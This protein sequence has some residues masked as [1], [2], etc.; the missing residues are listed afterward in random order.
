MTK[1]TDDFS[2]HYSVTP[3]AAPRQI[4]VLETGKAYAVAS[5]TGHHRSYASAVWEVVN[6]NAQTVQLRWVSGDPYY[7]DRIVLLLRQEW[8]LVEWTDRG[9]L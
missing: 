3:V 6:F 5:F 4:S 8:S 7:A 9:E 1:R 2:W